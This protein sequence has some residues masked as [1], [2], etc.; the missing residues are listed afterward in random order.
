MSEKHIANLIT[1]N[2]GQVSST[3]NYSNQFYSK[4]KRTYKIHL[5][6]YPN[7]TTQPLVQMKYTTP[8]SKN[9]QPYPWNIF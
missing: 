4:K 2:L 7:V 8:S 9:S 1:E 5:W 6:Q 3:K